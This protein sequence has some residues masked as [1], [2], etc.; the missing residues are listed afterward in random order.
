MAEVLG[1]A[2]AIAGLASLAIQLASGAKKIK[3][4]Y[5]LSKRLPDEI[6]LL[7]EDIDYLRRFME[8]PSRP[9]LLESSDAPE[10]TY[11]R[12][13]MQAVAE[14]LDRLA[15]KMPRDSNTRRL[16]SLGRMGQCKDELES[17][18]T[19]VRDAKLSLLML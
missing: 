7:T 12:N 5:K 1:G 13:C 10:A 8:Q 3:E 2:S 4:A 11:C 17:V 15:R 14:A 19:K 9:H 6:K 16:R 18:R